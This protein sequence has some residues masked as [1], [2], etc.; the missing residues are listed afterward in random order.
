M[1]HFE[2]IDSTNSYLEEQSAAAANEWPDFSV[3]VADAQTSGQ[4]RMGRGWVSPEGRSLS[5]SVLLRTVHAPG[6]LS[7]VAALS[8]VSTIRSL[9]LSDAIGLKWPNDVLVTGRKLAGILV[10]ATNAGDY[11]VGLGVNLRPISEFSES[12]ISLEEIGY[13]ATIDEFLASL[14][15]SL[16]ARYLRML[17]EPQQFVQDT[18]SEYSSECLT[19]GRSVRVELPD[20]QQIFGLANGIDDAGRLLVSIENQ[21]GESS[22]TLAL[23]AGDVW[24][25]RNL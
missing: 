2:S 4:G 17:I 8:L 10:R 21:F 1:E 20:E 25:L 24:H 13:E 22:E 6:W 11:V 5:L 3:V 18:R 9:G 12:A 7:P 19:I 15:A 16:R 14:L 23:A